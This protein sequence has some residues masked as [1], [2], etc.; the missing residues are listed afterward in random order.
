[1]K[2]KCPN[3]QGFTLIELMMTVAIV[4]ML[5]ATAIPAYFNYM[6]RTQVSEG[7][8][9]TGPAQKGIIEYF[10]E[11]GA[12]PSDN[13]TALLPDANTISGTYVQ[14]VTVADNVIA[15]KFGNEAHS[16]IQDQVVQLIAANVNNIVHWQC[17]TTIEDR[18]L[19]SI[20]R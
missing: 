15:V 19:P 11:T 16:I 2:I 8:S 3:A 4:G 17:D 10:T 9:L 13:S 18:Y 14:T 20:C 12:W 7:L 5:A 1:M 6:V